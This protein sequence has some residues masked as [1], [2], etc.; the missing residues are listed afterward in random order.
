MTPEEIVYILS[1]IGGGVMLGIVTIVLRLHI[2]TANICCGAIQFTR[3]ASSTIL[4]LQHSRPV[5]IERSNE[6][7]GT[8]QNTRTV[9][10][11]SNSQ[12][13]PEVSR[14]TQVNSIDI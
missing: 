9:H 4:G 1:S 3:S 10:V 11:N 12:T 8:P 2:R 6:R 14:V 13:S 5:I 7:H